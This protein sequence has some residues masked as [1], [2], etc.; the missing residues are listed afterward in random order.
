MQLSHNLA[1]R[2]GLLLQL[3]HLR[4][5]IGSQR[6]GRVRAFAFHFSALALLLGVLSQQ[7][8]LIL[9]ERRIIRDERV[10]CVVVDLLRMELLIDPV[11]EAD[12]AHLE[13]VAR[14]SAEAETTQRLDYLL[15]GRQLADVRARYNGFER[16]LRTRSL[17]GCANRC[18]AHQHREAY[19]EEFCDT[20]VFLTTSCRV[21]A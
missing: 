4:D 8:I 2:I 17:R 20:H 18:D 7:I 11:V 6:L 21:D 19:S 13:D 3:A 10:Q 14:F 16:S 15:V 5:L 9:I 1:A 12:R